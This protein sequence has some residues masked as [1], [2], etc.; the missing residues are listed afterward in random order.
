MEKLRR[1]LGGAGASLVQMVVSGFSD[2]LPGWSSSRV[3]STLIQGFEK[4]GRLWVG[5]AVTGGDRNLLET[6]ASPM[7]LG[8]H[9]W[10]CWL[11]GALAKSAVSRAERRIALLLPPSRPHKSRVWMLAGSVP[12]V[13]L[14]P[15]SP[16]QG[17]R[18]ATCGRQGAAA[19]RGALGGAGRSR[20]LLES[21]P[22]GAEGARVSMV[23]PPD[24]CGACGS[25]WNR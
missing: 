20:L 11:R 8:G 5:S 3:G 23:S 22:G 4:A 14:P 17:V 12:A 19:H 10:V 2:T 15:A 7:S 9:A 1:E 24:G 6:Q 18:R 21:R 25:M 13:A 16:R